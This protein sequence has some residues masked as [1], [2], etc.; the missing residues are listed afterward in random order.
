MCLF[1]VSSGGVTGFQVPYMCQKVTKGSAVDTRL[2]ISGVSKSNMEC[3]VS[4]NIK[5]GFQR[6]PQCHR[7][8]R[9]V[10]G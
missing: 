7:L 2:R 6:V 5:K 8:P 1:S 4:E 3:R 10:K 9:D